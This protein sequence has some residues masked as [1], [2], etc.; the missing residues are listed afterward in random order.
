M[1]IHLYIDIH[2]WIDLILY[3][4]C[5][6]QALY[7][8]HLHSSTFVCCLL[9]HL[10]IMDHIGLQPRKRTAKIRCILG[11]LV[12][13][14]QRAAKIRWSCHHHFQIHWLDFGWKPF[15]WRWNFVFR[16]PSRW[17]EKT[18][19]HMRGGSKEV[20]SRNFPQGR[21]AFFF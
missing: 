18:T 1:E 20:R 4:K 21:I 3:H 10:S 11:S 19:P 12:L 6:K 2:I 13:R 8:Y 15:C 5:I 9:P 17:F 14:C 16:L 7:H